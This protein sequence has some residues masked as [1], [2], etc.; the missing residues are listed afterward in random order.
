MSILWKK[1]KE[2]WRI[3][4]SVFLSAYLMLFFYNISTHSSNLTNLIISSLCS[5]CILYVTLNIV[6]QKQK[7]DFKRPALLNIEF[8]RILF[9]L[10]VL[11]VHFRSHVYHLWSGGGYAVEFFFILS[12]YFMAYSYRPERTVIDLAQRNWIRFAPLVIVGG[13]LSKGGVESFYGIFMIQY[14]GLGFA[15]IPNGPAWYIGVLFWIS[16]FY[17]SILRSFSIEKRHLIIGVLTFVSYLIIA[18]TGP[19][20]YIISDFIPHGLLRGIAGM[21]LGILIYQICTRPQNIENRSFLS[22]FIYSSLEL[23]LILYIISSFFTKEYFIEWWIFNPISHA[24]LLMLFI[25]KRGFI[26]SFLESPICSGFANYCLS[27]YL[28]HWC[29]YKYRFWQ[30]EGECATSIAL[31]IFYSVIL[32]I[33][34]H[35]F[36]EKPAA[37]YLKIMFDKLK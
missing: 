13:L 24:I 21:G 26:S 17:L 34:A 28:M 35:H 2:H 31:A 8:L 27:I 11:L 22:K 32:G 25:V 12:G 29:F 4:I 20:H 3:T 9:T 14:T 15:W 6:Q 1:I 7:K 18:R 19:V 16:L 33:L 30:I 10:G 37:K 36:V 5:G 23:L